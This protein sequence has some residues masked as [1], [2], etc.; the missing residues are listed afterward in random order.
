MNVMVALSAF[1]CRIAAFRACYG[2]DLAVK[3]GRVIEPREIA[4]LMRGRGVYKL[5]DKARTRGV[6]VA[7]NGSAVDW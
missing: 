7:A 3:T 4:N 1:H 5:I 2:G 6:R